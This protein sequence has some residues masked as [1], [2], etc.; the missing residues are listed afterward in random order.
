MNGKKARLRRRMMAAN[1]PEGNVVVKSQKEKALAR[2]RKS[3]L[4]D[5]DGMSAWVEFFDE[6]PHEATV[7]FANFVIHSRKAEMLR[8][9]AALEDRGVDVVWHL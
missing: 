1:N 2:L 3:G 5:E 6:N 7:N 9:I 8:F 4:F